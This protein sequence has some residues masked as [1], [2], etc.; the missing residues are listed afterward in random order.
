M[1]RFVNVHAG[2]SSRRA[3]PNLQWR[4]DVK[5]GAPAINFEFAGNDPGCCSSNRH[6][7]VEHHFF[8][9]LR[10]SKL[11]TF[12]IANLIHPHALHAR[13]SVSPS[14]DSSV[15]STSA[16]MFALSEESKVGS[17]RDG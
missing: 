6:P 15:A 17:S 9:L 11:E 7:I 10:S 12:P 13:S 2:P 14:N 5:N 16:N 3:S 1:S 4:F 8:S